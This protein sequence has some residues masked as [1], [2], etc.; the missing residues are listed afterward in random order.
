M[1]KF[2][3]LTLALAVLAAGTAA[4]CNDYPDPTTCAAHAECAWSHFGCVSKKAAQVSLLN[5]SS[6]AGWKGN[7]CEE[8]MGADWKQ[9]VSVDS[10]ACGKSYCPE[11]QAG[12]GCGWI[13]ECWTPGH[14]SDGKQLSSGRIEALSLLGVKAPECGLIFS[15]DEDRTDEKFAGNQ[16]CYFCWGSAQT[17]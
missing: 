11:R 16:S 14:N 10:G 12:T 3:V 6:V 7:S 15:I 8:V 13:K 9:K 17:R 4:I 2:H 1:P 5:S